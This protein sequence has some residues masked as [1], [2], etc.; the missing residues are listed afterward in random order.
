[1]KRLSLGYRPWRWSLLTVA[2]LPLLAFDRGCVTAPR[3]DTLTTAATSSVQ[4]HIG[5]FDSGTGNFVQFV[6]GWARLRVNAGGFLPWVTTNA[7]KLWSQSVPLPLGVNT[8][9]GETWRVVSGSVVTGNVDP[10]LL[11]RKNDLSNRGSQQVYFDFSDPDINAQL[12]AIASATLTGPLT[13]AQLNTFAADV[14]TEVK[15][16]FASAYSCNAV[17]V[18]N[19]PGADVHTVLVHGYDSCSLYGQSPGDYKNLTKAQT[20]DLYVGTFKCVM[21]DDGQLLGNTP[22]ALSD[23]L[24]TRVRDVGTA[25]GRT[26]AHEVGHSLGL[27]ADGSLL[28]GCE[29]WHNCEA[30]DDA[31]PS[32]R[33]DTGHHIMDPGPKSPLYARIGQAN[34]LTRSPRRPVFEAY[35]RSYLEIIHP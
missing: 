25:I 8:V 32:D 30:Y 31:N 11:E 3:Q 10:F 29:G 16:F 6:P 7:D 19:A 28:H 26:A 9:R 21:V 34:P 20:T 4:G 13:A 33:F 14:K 2:A 1:M 35:G 15:N 12:K 5:E 18:V 23:S 27:T 24:A 22:A 17:T